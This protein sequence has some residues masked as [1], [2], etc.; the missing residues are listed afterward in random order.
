MPGTSLE[1]PD[2]PMF[3]HPTGV[4]DLRYEKTWLAGKSMTFLYVFKGKIIYKW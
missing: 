2:L 3:F 4:A 1:M